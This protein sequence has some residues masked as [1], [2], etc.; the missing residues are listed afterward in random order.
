MRWLLKNNLFYVKKPFS[1]RNKAVS[2]LS[3]SSNLKSWNLLA[4]V[5]EKKKKNWSDEKYGSAS[6]SHIGNY[7]KGKNQTDHAKTNSGLS[8]MA[9]MEKCRLKL[10]RFINLILQYVCSYLKK[11]KTAVTVL[12]KQY[13][14]FLYKRIICINV[15]LH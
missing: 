9:L 14:Y 13:F 4:F 1:W 8:G 3:L 5:A 10:Y 12:V 11:K 7:C 2:C 6:N 15:K